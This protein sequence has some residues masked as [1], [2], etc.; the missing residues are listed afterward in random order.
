MRLKNA[1]IPAQGWRLPATANIV[2][3]HPKAADPMDEPVQPVIVI[4]KKKKEYVAPH[5]GAWKVAYADFVTAVLALFIVLWLITSSEKVQK[6]VGGYFND[7]RGQGKDL[8][9]GVRANGTEPLF[10]NKDE[11]SRLRETLE[12]ALKQEQSLQK[13]KDNVVMSVTTEGLR[14]E[15]IEGEGSLFFES[16]SPTPTDAGKQLL[17]KLAAE[18]G[19]L[20]NKVA[21]E[22]HT[23]AQPFNGRPGYSNWELSTD[24]ANAARRLMQSLGLR[25]DQV[26]QV[27]GFAEQSPRNP[28]D[29]ADPSNR[30][31]T[32]IIQNS[33]GKDR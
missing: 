16:G 23:D 9:N 3:C 29:P 13:I 11:M 27:R 6:S 22:G 14:V 15:L 8:G 4:R 10:V 20:P 17:G 32:V 25:D 21:I 33:I 12:Q 5:G 18:I 1:F 30:R 19:Q 28:A 7:P 31:V 24:R 26:T 2:R